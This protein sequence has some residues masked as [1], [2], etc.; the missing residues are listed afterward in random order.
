MK[1]SD[2]YLSRTA[3]KVI[4]DGVRLGDPVPSAMREELMCDLAV[5]ASADYAVKKVLEWC[6]EVCEEHPEVNYPE[7]GT[8]LNKRHDCP[9]CWE[10]LK[11]LVE[12]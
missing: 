8:H 11:K 2:L 6:D 12:T 5:E 9:L 3:T 4:R 10:A 1:K 7:V